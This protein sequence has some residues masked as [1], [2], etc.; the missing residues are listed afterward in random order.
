MTTYNHLFDFAF[1]IP[2]CQDPEGNVTA[3]QIRHAIFTR[4]NR[5]S[6]EELLEAI[7]PPLDTYVED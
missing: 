4:L 6:D 2:G 3:E 1:Q 5:L 7:G